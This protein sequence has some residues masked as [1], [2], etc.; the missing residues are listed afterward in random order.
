MFSDKI[1]DKHTEPKEYRLGVLLY[2]GERIDRDIDE[3]ISQFKIAWDNG[4]I[5]SGYNYAILLRKKGQ[6][7][8]ADQVFRE[9]KGSIPDAWYYIS[10]ESSDPYFCLS[11]GSAYGS[12]LCSV[13]FGWK[14]LEEGKLVGA[15][16][17][18]ETA[19]IS[20]EEEIKDKAIE[21]LGVVKMKEGD[22]AGALNELFYASEKGSTEGQYWLGMC[23]LQTKNTTG[24]CN[25][26]KKASD[27]GH[28]KATVELG[29]IYLDNYKEEEGVKLLKSVL[30]DKEAK[31]KLT[32]YYLGKKKF[33][34]ALAYAE[35]ED[36]IT[37]QAFDYAVDPSRDPREAYLILDGIRG[38]H[39]EAAYRLG[40]CY[41]DG[42][43]CEKD[44]SK[45]YECFQES[46]SFMGWM[47][48]SKFHE[49]G[50]GGR[51]VDLK[52]ALQ[53]LEEEA[54]NL[55]WTE[56]EGRI[57][58]VAK[59]RIKGK[60]NPKTFEPLPDYEE[61][62][63]SETYVEVPKPRK[64]NSV[65][66]IMNGRRDEPEWLYIAGCICVAEG[67]DKEAEEFFKKGA[68]AGNRDC[69]IKLGEMVLNDA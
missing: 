10:F 56:D 21:G 66:M 1:I 59:E 36:E 49:Y 20:T 33:L 52:L 69:L 55:A 37:N 17:K 46:N 41:L 65:E 60:M 9:I 12:K 40:V 51:D 54:Q 16:N 6:K 32:E 35:D 43:G 31:K 7:V 61:E 67:D 24:A 27:K 14:L 39:G 19:L 11:Q 3:A 53:F 2:K 57:L 63:G 42:L 28:E 4:H 68:R 15:R 45:A 30:K 25:E 47:E 62:S 13:F 34:E 29:K 58:N 44:L 5:P 64:P 26:F 22:Y 48:I 50:K 8:K 38:R 18:F 23:Y